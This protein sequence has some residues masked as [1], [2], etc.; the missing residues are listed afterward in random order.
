MTKSPE[1]LSGTTK[2]KKVLISKHFPEIYLK[3][4]FNQGIILSIMRHKLD[5]IHSK[6]E[7]INTNYEEVNDQIKIIPAISNKSPVL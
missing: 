5:K 1:R 3:G 4:V 2:K 7:K 6:V